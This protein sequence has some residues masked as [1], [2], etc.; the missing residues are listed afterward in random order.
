MEYR[1]NPNLPTIRDDWRGNPVRDGVFQYLEEDFFP[2][3]RT[4][5]RM[6]TSPNPQ[7]DEKKADQ[8]R[9]PAVEGTDWLTD[10]DADF[11]RWLGHATFVIQLGGVR[12]ITDPVLGNMPMTPR[13]A[14]TPVPTKAVTGL[15]YILLS[16]DHRD[17]TDKATLQSL[18]RRNRPRKILAPLGMDRTISR[19]VGDTPLEMAAWYQQYHL[20]GTDLQITFLPTRH[21]S[22]RGLWDFNRV[23]WGAFLLEYRGRRIYFGGDSAYHWHY[24]DT[25]RRFPGIDIAMLGIGAYA[26]DYM[27]QAVHTNPEEAVQ[28]WQELGARRLLPMHYGTFD[29]SNEPIS[30]PVRRVRAAMAEA[31][32]TDRLLLPALNEP[33]DLAL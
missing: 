18:L 21:W 28:A 14:P 27:M 16:H 3:W 7:R 2:E 8:W 29:L 10:R 4:V 15:D 13:L 1:L 30:E 33:V 17:H 12:L 25:G 19:W 22:R 26:P 9:L 11:I 24:A 32:A 20:P 31:G 5:W 23:L 6:M